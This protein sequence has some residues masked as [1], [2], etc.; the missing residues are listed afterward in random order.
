MTPLR[1]VIFEDNGDFRESLLHLFRFTPDVEVIGAYPDCSEV[2]RIITQLKPEVV[3]MDIDMPGMNGIEATAVVKDAS[4]ST[5]VVMLTVSEEE[6]RI[7]QA[8]RNGATG[9]LLKKSGPDELVDSVRLVHKGGSPMS[10]AIARKVLQF[11]HLNHISAPSAA[12][13]T[14]ANRTIESDDDGLSTGLT[15]REQEI[16]EALVD[17]L[18][19]KMIAAKHF[20]STDTVKNHIQGIYRKLHVNSKGEA[21][22]YA[23]KRGIAG[24]NR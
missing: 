12:A 5:Q 10:P 17:G 9:Y 8:L 13:A 1:L 24:N 16:L 14:V 20:I 6:D 3:L 18:S 15:P 4:P 19:Y 2:R 22:S 11:F 7:F 23:L 21:I